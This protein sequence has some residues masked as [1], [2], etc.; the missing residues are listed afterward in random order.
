MSGG[1]KTKE[2][3]L[4]EVFKWGKSAEIALPITDKT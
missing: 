1:S 4:R 2:L 3:Q